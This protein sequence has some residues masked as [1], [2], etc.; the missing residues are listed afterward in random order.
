MSKRVS[1]VAQSG[2]YAVCQS[3]W[4]DVSDTELVDVDAGCQ[5][6]KEIKLEGSWKRL[7]HHHITQP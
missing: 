6:P 1:K 5:S 3:G 4:D 2:L 7:G